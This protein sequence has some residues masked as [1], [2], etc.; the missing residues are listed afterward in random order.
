MKKIYFIRH[1]ESE[2][3]AGG[4][5]RPENEIELTKIGHEQADFV[6]E[7]VKNLDVDVIIASTLLRARQTAE[8]ISKETGIEVE[9]SPLFIERRYPSVGIGLTKHHPTVQEIEY[10]MINR[11]EDETAV[12]SDEE[13]FVELKERTI[14]ALEYLTNRPEENILVVTHG[15][16]LRMLV[17]AAIFG[18]TLTQSETGKI[19]NV[20]KTKNTGISFLEYDFE[21]NPKHPW[22]VRVWNDHAHLG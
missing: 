8:H 9:T 6:G 4:I 10:L 11:F 21:T 1:G 16:F 3:N 18:R 17:A 2:A 15:I 19:V 12:H 20:F 22:V 5:I 13:T 14:Q 7:R